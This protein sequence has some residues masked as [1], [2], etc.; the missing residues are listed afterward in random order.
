MP[1][2]AR[3]TSKFG[4]YHVMLRGIDRTQLF[5]DDDDRIAFMERLV[6]YKEEC[7]FSLLAWCLMANHVHLLIKENAVSLSVIMKKL[8]LSYSNYFNAKYDRRGY[9]FEDR[10]KSEPIE[11]DKYL[12]AVVRYIHRNPLEIGEQ[13]AHWTSYDEYLTSPDIADTTLILGILDPTMKRPH[14]AFK[15]FV[16]I[17]QDTTY[18]F[19]GDKSPK[20]IKDLEAMKMI[21]AESGLGSCTDLFSLEKEARNKVIASLRKKGLSIRQIARLTGINRGIVEAAKP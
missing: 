10:Y 15:E 5:Y 6:R 8:E 20:H 4:L 11:S 21:L 17:P 14:L 18:S 13:M 19:I 9:L 7:E 16:D 3:Q 1:R 2:Q 12:L